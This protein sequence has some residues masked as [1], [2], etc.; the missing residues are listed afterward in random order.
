MTKKEEIIAAL[1]RMGY[2]PEYDE[3]GDIVLIYQMKTL[4]LFP[5]KEDESYLSVMLPRYFDIKEGDESLTLAVCNKMNRELK[6]VKTYLDENFKTVTSVCEFYYT[7][8]SS[9][10][11]G[12]ENALNVLGVIRTIYRRTVD[13]FSVDT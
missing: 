8:D 13:D 7:D 9:L 4:Y 10:E 2:N 5:G 3:D 12:I 1:K 6:V 11:D